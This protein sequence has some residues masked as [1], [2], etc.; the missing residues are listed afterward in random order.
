M[1][2]EA[3]TILEQVGLVVPH[4]PTLQVVTA[5]AGAKL[6]GGRVRLSRQLVTDQT[7]EIGSW[8]EFTLLSGAYSLKLLDMD[9]GEVRSPTLND[10]VQTTRLADALGMEVIAPVTPLDVPERLREL[11]MYRCV[12]ENAL[13]GVGGGVL[14]NAFEADFIWEMSQ[15]VGKEITLG[16]WVVSPLKLESGCLELLHHFRGKEDVLTWPATMPMCGATGPIDFPALFTQSIAET[17]GAATVLKLLGFRVAYRPKDSFMAY[18]FDMR[19]GSIAYGSPEHILFT[20]LQVQIAGHFGM[21]PAAK[22]LVTCSKRPDAQAAAEKASHTALA[23]LAGAQ[24][25]SNAGMLSIDEIY[26]PVQAVIDR[27][28]C[29][30]CRRVQQGCAYDGAA[31]S[32][33]LLADAE[34]PFLEREKTLSQYR[35]VYR[36]SQLFPHMMHEQWVNKGEHVE[37]LARSIAREKLRSHEF[38]LPEHAA[39]ELERIYAA[40]VKGAHAAP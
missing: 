26:S 17:L 6:Q 27:E 7:R 16:L 33:E 4:Q 36:F 5:H 32:S 13:R 38:H 23:M 8:R 14:T 34:T 29:E 20:L 9:S 11:A 19:H 2:E 21:P 12:W 39:Q 30:H 10:L 25:F 15:V 3:L 31:L 18:P 24:S 1:H 28:I 40:A 37:K 35:D 22:S